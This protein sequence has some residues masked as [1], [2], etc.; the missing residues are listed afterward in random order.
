MDYPEGIK[1]SLF[2]VSRSTSKVIFGI[3]NHRP[4]GP[5]LHTGEK[6]SKY[7]FRGVD[8]LVEE[9]WDRVRKEGFEL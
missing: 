8:H 1:F 2:L 3:D 5:H 7:E 6:E 9:F 4:K